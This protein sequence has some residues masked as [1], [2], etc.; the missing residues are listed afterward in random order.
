M[1]KASTLLLSAAL[2]KHYSEDGRSSSR[3]ERKAT[4]FY[5]LGIGDDD[6]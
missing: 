6:W 1:T 2:D 3:L 5:T 4:A